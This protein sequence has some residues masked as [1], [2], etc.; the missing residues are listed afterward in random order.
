M[1]SVWVDVNDPSLSVN[2]RVFGTNDGIDADYSR[3]LVFVNDELVSNEPMELG[4]F[5][6]QWPIGAFMEP[7]STTLTVAVR[8]WFT[9]DSDGSASHTALEVSHID[10]SG[11]YA[12]QWDEDPSCEGVG[13]QFLTEDN[14]G[15][16]LPFLSRCSDDRAAV[17][18]LAVSFT[19][20]CLLYTSP[21]PRDRG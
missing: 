5:S 11:G 6:H 8:A 13:D 14:G 7:G 21:S 15:L 17:D 10:V 1:A 12:I 3:W 9:W 2:G 4:T 19:N 18:D 16:I 20:T